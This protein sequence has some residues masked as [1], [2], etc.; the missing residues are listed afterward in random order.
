MGASAT[1]SSNALGIAHEPRLSARVN[2]ALNK[3]L[4]LPQP[5][6]GFAVSVA[7]F[8]RQRRPQTRRVLKASGSALARSNP[9]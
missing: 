7:W 9:P 3:F 6:Q 1:D 4:A 8:E 5:Q 2:R